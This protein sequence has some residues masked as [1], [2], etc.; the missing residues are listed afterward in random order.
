MQVVKHALTAAG[1]KLAYSRNPKQPGYHLRNLPRVSMALKAILDKCVAEVNQSQLEI[2]KKL[3]FAQRF[4]QGCPIS[5][6]SR[7]TVAHRNR[8]KNP[9][10][11]IAEAQRLAIKDRTES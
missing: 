1:F 2:S 4:Q 3:T 7:N 10:L 6:L 8:Q 9:N 5:N 11:N